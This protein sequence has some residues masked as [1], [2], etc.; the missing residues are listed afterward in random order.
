MIESPKERPIIFSAAMVRAIIE[1]HKTQTRRVVNPQPADSCRNPFVGE[2]KIWRFECAQTLRGPIS[3]AEDDRRCPYGQPGDRLWVRETFR[4]GFQKTMFSEGIIFKVDAPKALGMDEYSDR[5]VWSPS[6]HMPRWAS[7]LTLELI[8][9]RVERLQEISVND[10]LA[11]GIPPITDADQW[12][13][14]I[15]KEPNLPAIYIG[16]YCRLWDRI[17]AKRAPWES[18]PWVWVLEFKRVSGGKHE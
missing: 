4:T 14:P 3:N 6:I 11:E 2:D 8:D 10:C 12:S 15:P 7:L 5:R 9:V 1:G 18:N 13:K 17:N 16:A